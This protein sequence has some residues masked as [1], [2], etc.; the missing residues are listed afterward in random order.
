MNGIHQ[1]EMPTTRHPSWLVQIE[2]FGAKSILKLAI[3]AV[4]LI[5][6][7]ILIAFIPGIDRMSD[8]LSV[9]VS[10]LLNTAITIVL[11]AIIVKIA[12]QA[13]ELIESI[14]TGSTAF[15]EYIAAVQYWV[16]I[17][18]AVCIA[19]IGFGDASRAL[20]DRAG[21]DVLH[22][23]VFLILGLVPISI[24]LVELAVYLQMR[25]QSGSEQSASEDIEILQTNAE[26]VHGLLTTR[27]GRMQ[28]G[29]IADATNWSKTKV[30]YVLSDMEDDGLI[31]RYRVGREKIVCL[32]GHEPD[33]VSAPTTD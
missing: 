20:L 23:L 27:G 10:P 29:E 16:V 28:Q 26:Q 12:R 6:L 17:L 1:R 32:P 11:I 3:A 9:P 5:Y 33:V 7:A 25:R 19:Y 22:P 13:R 2:R 18:V 24:L 31:V 4:G 21:F 15:R 8:M 30:S 14:E